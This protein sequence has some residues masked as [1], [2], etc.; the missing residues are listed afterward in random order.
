MY[1]RVLDQYSVCTWSIV[2]LYLP[3]T[4]IMYWGWCTWRVLSMY[5]KN[6]L[7]FYERVFADA[8]PVGCDDTHP[9]LARGHER[10]SEGQVHIKYTQVHSLKYTSVR[11]SKYTSKYT[12]VHVKYILTCTHA[13][14]HVYLLERTR[15]YLRFVYLTCTCAAWSRACTYTC[16]CTCTCAYL[17]CWGVHVL[18]VQVHGEY[19]LS[20]CIWNKRPPFLK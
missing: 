14:T 20:T 2:E 1:L 7:F 5:L 13:C 19:T 16:T 18:S 17:Q 12:W 9:G 8:A 6:V 15:M 11:S 10:G 3:C 4:W